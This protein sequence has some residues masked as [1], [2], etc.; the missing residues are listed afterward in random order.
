MRQEEG[1][2]SRLGGEELCSMALGER[3]EE[4]KVEKT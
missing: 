1:G 4:R 3:A 2:A